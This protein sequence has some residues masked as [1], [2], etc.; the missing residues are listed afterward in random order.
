MFLNLNEIKNNSTDIL[1]KHNHWTKREVNFR[2][3]S[4][5]ISTLNPFYCPGPSQSRFRR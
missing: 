4:Y 3:L 2:I 5:T 1:L